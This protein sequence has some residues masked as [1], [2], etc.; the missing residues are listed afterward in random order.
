MALLLVF[1]TQAAWAQSSGATHDLTLSAKLTEKGTTIDRGI[2]WRVFSDQT[3]NKKTLPL[4]QSA[5]GGTTVLKLPV[6]TYLV[7]AGFG[8]AGASKLIKHEKGGTSQTLVLDAGGLKLTAQSAGSKVNAQDLRFSIFAIDRDEDGNRELIAK[9]LRAN[10]V[11]RLNTGTYHVESTYGQ[12]NASVRADLEVNAGK[13][14]TATLQHRG[15]K[16][17]LKFVARAGGNPL[18][19][20]AW[21]VLTDESEKVFESNS[22]SPSLILSEGIYEAS[23]RN[24][25]KTYI[26]NFEVKAGQNATVEVLITQ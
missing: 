6:G 25:A 22:V 20:T 15:A 24:G 16:I 13:V 10:R 17:M 5:S 9:D 12:I 3:G 18:A 7:H 21:T 11:I 1:L 26:K 23:A 14:T 19:N 4:L 2:V 8:R